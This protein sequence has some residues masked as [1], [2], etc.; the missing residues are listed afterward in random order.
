MAIVGSGVTSLCP[1]TEQI[2]GIAAERMLSRDIFAPAR[3]IAPVVGRTGRTGTGVKDATRKGVNLQDSPNMLTAVGLYSDEFPM[4]RDQYTTYTYAL[5]LFKL[6]EFQLPDR[7]RAQWANVALVDQAARVAEAESLI[8]EHAHARLV[9][10]AATTAANWDSNHAF[11]GGNITST[12]YDFMDLCNDARVLLLKAQT[13]TPG[14]ELAVVIP[15]DVYYHVQR[16]D[17]ARYSV[18]ALSAGSGGAAYLTEDMVQA[19]VGGVLPGAKVYRV[20][21]YYT[22]ASGTVTADMTGCILFIPVVNGTTAPLVTN[23]PLD[24]EGAIDLISL[25]SERNEK[26]PADI[27]YAELDCS[28]QV[29]ENTG[30]VL[31]HTLLS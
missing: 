30:A 22:A 19:F 8:A 3:A 13:W 26:I 20:S 5:T 27:F 25:R 18:G 15:D 11:D 29:I 24:T 16:L 7:I 9:Y 23:A 14:A 12:S 28:V 4:R 17:Q 2:A 6:D 21:S 31:A 10:S 1:L